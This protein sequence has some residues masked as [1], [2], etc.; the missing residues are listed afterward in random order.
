MDGKAKIKTSSLLNGLTK[1]QERRK[2]I[3]YA[4][5]YI[6]MQCCCWIK[7]CICYT[8]LKRRCL[9]PSVVRTVARASLP[10]HLWNPEAF[11]LVDSQKTSFSSY[12]DF[13]E[14]CFLKP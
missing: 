11:Y 3:K 7:L 5:R 12:W 1:N 13:Q 9:L 2:P 6:V 8:L 4:L 10:H 14:T